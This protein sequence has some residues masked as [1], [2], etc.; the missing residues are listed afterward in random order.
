VRKVSTA[1]DGSTD[2]PRIRRIESRTGR[3]ATA[4][5]L[6]LSALFLAAGV[7][8]DLAACGGIQ[9]PAVWIP[10]FSTGYFVAIL[11]AAVGR[12]PKSGFITAALAAI[13]RV[14]LSAV[15]SQSIA[16]EGALAGVLF[17]GLAAGYLVT[18]SHW[19]K[20][21]EVRAAREISGNRG[22]DT[23]GAGIIADSQLPG[24]LEALRA[25]I[26]AIESAGYVLEDSASMDDNHRE[27]AAILLKE[28]HRL[29]VLVRSAKLTGP[30][31]P[32]FQETDLSSI[33][34]E[35]LRMGHALADAELVILRKGECPELKLICDAE[36][37]EQAI[38]NLLANAI[39]VV[40]RG[41]KIEL[42]AHANKHDAVIEIVHCNRSVL[43]RLQMTMAATRKGRTNGRSA[44]R[45]FPGA[46]LV[47][48]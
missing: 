3:L 19:Q 29:D 34:D 33:L 1:L 15:C 42:S 40:D 39:R 43:V 47:N 44:R 10:A 8:A 4:F 18:R 27:V 13:A 9:L 6:I 2:A 38:L 30:A 21:S 28:C 22:I 24:S 12:G 23:E 35:V 16:Q 36:L 37:V 48:S 14:T 25:P 46:G 31:R 17:T 45:A 41:E 7:I 11:L 26:S 20:T 5:V 32:Y